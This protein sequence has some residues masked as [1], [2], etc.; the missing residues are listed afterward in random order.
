MRQK[1][2]SLLISYGYSGDGAEKWLKAPNRELGGSTPDSLISAGAGQVVLEL[3][4]SWESG[5]PS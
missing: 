3:I 5:T 4:L 2:K 1:I